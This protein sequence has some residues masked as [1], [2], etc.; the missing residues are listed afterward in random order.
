MLEAL[1]GSI[2]GSEESVCGGGHCCVVQVG[3]VVN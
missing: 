3:F 1:E 2:L